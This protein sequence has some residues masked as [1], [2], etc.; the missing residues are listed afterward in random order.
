MNP[1]WSL[2]DVRMFQFDDVDK[3][4]ATL[5]AVLQHNPDFIISVARLEEAQFH[6]VLNVRVFCLDSAKP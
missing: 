4:V 3:L 6:G 5:P 1:H 2:G